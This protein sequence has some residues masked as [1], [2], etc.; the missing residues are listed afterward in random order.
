MVISQNVSLMLIRLLGVDTP[1]NLHES[2]EFGGPVGKEDLCADWAL[3]IERQGR[4]AS[5][6]EGEGPVRGIAANRKPG[7]WEK[8][9]GLQV[10]SR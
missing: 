2:I 9:S 4:Q 5:F 6:H 1:Q 10:R 7:K 3:L 8:S